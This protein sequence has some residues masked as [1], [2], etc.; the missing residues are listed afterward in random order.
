VG[1]SGFALVHPDD[2]ATVH[3]AFASVVQRSNPG[4]PTEYRFRHAGGE[5]VV[6]ESVARNLLDQPA[7]GGIVLTTRVITERRQA[8]AELRESRRRLSTLLSNL[9]GMAYRCRNDLGGR[10]SW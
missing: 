2:L 3:A 8:E 10:W 6:V 5:W 9:P 1:K 7:V 4:T